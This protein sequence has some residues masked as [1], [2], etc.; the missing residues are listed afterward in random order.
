ME[1][2]RD[3]IIDTNDLIQ[4]LGL[5]TNKLIGIYLIKDRL[6]LDIADNIISNYWLT[7]IENPTRESLEE[8]V[9]KAHLELEDVEIKFHEEENFIA[10]IDEEIKQ[11]SEEADKE[12]YDSLMENIDIIKWVGD[13]NFNKYEMLFPTNEEII[14]GDYLNQLIDSLIGYINRSISNMGNIERKIRMRRLLAYMDLP[15]E[16][17]EDFI[18]YIYYAL[19]ERVVNKGGDFIYT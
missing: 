1:D 15:F 12:I 7:Y 14:T 17:F 6:E 8:L 19:D 4:F 5:M 10:E 2:L 13:N 11:L 3:N 18:E 16:D 9:Y